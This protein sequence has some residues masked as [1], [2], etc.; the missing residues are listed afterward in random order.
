[1][2]FRVKQAGRYR[3]LQ[4]AE[5]YREGRR[6]R[7]RVLA[8]LGNLDEITAAG[9]L[10][11]LLASGARF[12]E[13][14]AVLDARRDGTLEPAR[15]VRIGPDEVF[16]RV[17]EQLGI[18]ET[19]RQTAGAR[20][21]RFDP[22]RAVYLT[23]MHR[24]FEAG[25]DRSAVLWREPYRLPGCE[26][27][28]LHQIYRAMGWLGSAL[29]DQAGRT[30]L[31]PRCVKDLIE[32]RLFACRRDL[33]SS[34][35]VVF[36]DTTTIYF[37]GR[38]G[39][40]LGQRGKSKD[41]RP[42]LPQMVVA[43]V[44]DGEGMPLCCEMWP[45]NTT[46]VKTLLPVVER[47]RAR[48]RIG[49]VC[50][51][52]DRGMISRDILTQLDEPDCTQPYILGVRMR[53]VKAVRR[54]V[55]GRA[56]RYRQVRDGQDGRDPLAVKEVWHEGRRYVVCRNPAQA[57][58]DRLAREQIV[59]A[60]RKKLRDGE[61]TMVG[62]KGFRK[63]L[64]KTAAKAFEI[65]ERKVL[66]E[67]RYDGRWVLTTNT[68]LTA[69][70]VAVQYKLLWTIEDTFRTMKTVL[71]TRPVFH[72]L[73]R[74]IRGHV[75][76]SFLA[77]MVRR[78]LEGALQAAGLD[79]EWAHVIASLR[80]VQ[81]AEA[82]F[83]GRPVVIRSEMAGCSTHLFRAVGAPIPPA[84]RFPKSRTR[85]DGSVVPQPGPCSVTP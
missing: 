79:L 13:K 29:A 76:C 48:F 40:T 23:V 24:L 63:Y 62:N 50:I 59:A 4:I 73:D 83:S 8:T 19:L 43:V 44:L 54:H 61:K 57:E 70:E 39:E 49:Q 81:E 30:A 27:I 36:F 72:R 22:E 2:Y 1:M 33:F 37:E 67:A 3:Y 75:F 7:Q 77:L 68:T 71:E 26:S 64:R 34:L 65:D 45:G 82:D 74:T 51:V 16:R 78:R 52:A 38:G 69:A 28:E 55:L 11:A 5:S 53:A 41:S 66:E 6:V 58:R 20:R 46:D 12:S 15:F 47:L 17:W 9:G 56:G 60:L 84:V 32:E 42:D 21:F 80:E 14:L 31:G 35:S 10:D 25:S 18:G 85:G